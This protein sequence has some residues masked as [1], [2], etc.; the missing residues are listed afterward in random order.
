MV[1]IEWTEEAI[2]WLKD[3]H[4]YVVKD[5]KRIVKKITKEIYNKVQI[6]VTFSQK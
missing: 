2:F 1:K 4:D 6:L 5:N 3:I